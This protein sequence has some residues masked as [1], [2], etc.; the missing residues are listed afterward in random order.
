MRLFVT[1]FLFFVTSLAH[2][3]ADVSDTTK[4]AS[5][6]DDTAKVNLM[7]KVSEELRDYDTKQGINIGKL[8][9]ELAERLKFDEGKALALK[10]IGANY[11]RTGVYELAL[12]NFIESLE[13]Y[14]KVGNRYMIG[15]LNNNIGLVY[16]AR[17]QYNKSRSYYSESLKIADELG[18]DN[19]RARVNHNLALIEYEEG[20][21]RAAINK[22][23][24]S[25]KFAQLAKDTMLMGYNYCFTGKCYTKLRILDSAEMFISKSIEIFKASG[26]DNTMAMAYNQYANMLNAKGKA[27][28]AISYAS[29]ASLLGE[30]VG[31]RY[32]KMESAD[33]IAKAYTA[34]KNFEKAMQF[35]IIY[36]ELRDTMK[37]EN[38]IQTIAQ[39][40][41]G[42][43]YKNEIDQLK[44]EKQETLYKNQM[45]ARSAIVAVVLLLVIL[46][47]LLAFYR[48]KV[49]TNNLLLAKNSEIT[50]LNTKLEELNHTKDKFFSIIA[51]DLKN[52]LGTFRD[53]TKMLTSDLHKFT[54]E[55]RTELLAMIASSAD[56]LYALLINLL[57]WSRSQRGTI[58][59]QPEE[60]MMR[61]LASNAIA[62]L[63]GVAEQKQIDLLNKISPAMIVRADTNM[64][65]TVLRNLVSNAIKFTK[66]GGQIE[67][68]CKDCEESPAQFIVAYVRDNGVG[69]SEATIA[70]LFRIDETIT[71]IGTSGER[72]T[73][74]GLILCKEF[75]EKHGGSM[76]VE[77]EIGK[78]STFFF[79]LPK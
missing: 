43:K 45:I 1:L 60:S 34:L 17:T 29:M 28:E 20:N 27:S 14:K 7:A 11:W 79:R 39:I 48:L 23:Q 50:A 8:A 73:G 71:S 49:R 37:N 30:K 46:L 4:L 42:Y 67:I 36:Y 25:F 10:A 44:Y 35:K 59:F 5:M 61:V 38:N 18:N 22:H 77:S 21:I 63:I 52:P 78:G 47:I 6:P 15:R 69:M 16:F 41:A 75:I 32:M 31:N 56:N 66:A 33:I 12:Q 2:L 26:N 19:E 64:L 24:L 76:W 68:G 55:E 13:L 74:L 70:K 62:P 57:D 54:D 40:E 3:R 9:I 51:H 53:A 72:G 58:S 65:T